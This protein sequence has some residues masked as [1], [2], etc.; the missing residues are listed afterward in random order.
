LPA[1]NP[2]YSTTGNRM[3]QYW[4]SFNLAPKRIQNGGWSRQITQDDFNIS[5]TI[6]GVKMRLGRGA[7]A[8]FTGASKQNGPS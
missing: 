7:F 4:A 3:P 2:L 5:T 6:S 8:S 1:T